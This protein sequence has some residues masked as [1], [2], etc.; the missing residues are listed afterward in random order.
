MSELARVLE[1]VKARCEV[2]DVEDGCWLWPNNRPHTPITRYKGEMV[3][4]RRLIAH[5]M[6]RVPLHG[7]FRRTAPS[8]GHR[9]CVAPHHAEILTPSV[10]IRRAMA[11]TGAGPQRAVKIA[12]VKRKTAKLNEAAVEDIRTCGLPTA[13]LAK[14]Y[15]V[16]TST[17]IAVRSGRLW[18]RLPG[19]PW[20]G[21]F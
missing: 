4:V 3:G 8:C 16:H 14:K 17:I 9:N 21:L 2:E 19:N 13:E 1:R 6:G 11:R 15:G 7:Q 20:A 12:M 10:S 5:L 18:K